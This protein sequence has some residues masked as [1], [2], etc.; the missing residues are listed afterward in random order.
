MDSEF[1]INILIVDDHPENLLALEAIIDNPEYQLIRAY[2]GEDALRSLLKMNIAVIVMDVEMPGLSGFET[3]KLI[4]LNEKFKLIPIIFISATSKDAD[5]QFTAYSVGAV[6]YMVKPFVPTVLKSKIDSFVNQYISSKQLQIQSELL[7][8]KTLEL[9][10]ANSELM[11]TAYKLSKAEAQAKVVQNTSI[12]TMITF[13]EEG[14][15]LTVNP[16]VSEMFGYEPEELENRHVS[17]LIP[18][19]SSH[20]KA[21]IK[22]IVEPKYLVGKFREVLTYRKDGSSFPAEIQIGEAVV[23]NERLFACTVSDITERKQA[24]LKML[25]AKEAAEIT[26]R[27]RTEF[28]AMM[29]HEIRT[30]MNGVLGMTDLLLETDL[31]SEQ[32]EYAQIIRKSGDALV[33]V[34]NHILDFTKIESGKMELEQEP[35]L[36]RGCIEETFN[37]FTAKSKNKKLDLVYYMDDSI[38]EFLIGDVT[39]LRQILINL[40]GNALKFTSKGGVYVLVTLLGKE[41]D[42]LNIEFAIKD[43]GIGI[44]QEKAG[45]LF[46]PF[47]QLDPSMTRKYGG[48]G[49]GLN[50]CRSLVEMMDGEIGLEPQADTGTTFVFNIKLRYCLMEECG[51]WNHHCFLPEGFEWKRTQMQK[52]PKLNPDILPG[53]N[54]LYVD[55][56][57]INGKL[58]ALILKQL[59]QVPAA[60]SAHEEALE[61]LHGGSWEL[62]W[63]DLQADPEGAIAFA[64][65]IRALTPEE[66]QPTLVGLASDLAP[67]VREECLKAGFDEVVHK[68]MTL[69]TAERILIRYAEHFKAMAAA[70]RS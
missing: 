34:V 39:R 43:T 48:T 54:C 38:P 36:L 3:A 55:E 24:E 29:S 50:I 41:D 21:I 46:E 11:K 61:R 30:P 64:Q 37:L 33:S 9:E 19:I 8:L 65:Q 12:D 60:C 15:I 40:V 31:N 27:A 1:P 66:R 26:A 13:N 20:E 18:L 56:S 10:N 25:Q 35:F 51:E 22:G 16:A 47:S 42:K 45:L 69:G 5:H 49:L 70:R 59:Q 7:R 17:I 14:F 62:V 2:S 28:L 4:K 53:L 44:A 57:I 32:R 6:D 67:E 63:V 23:H 68:P 52:S 58:A